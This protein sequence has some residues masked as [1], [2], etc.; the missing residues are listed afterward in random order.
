MSNK[1][2]YLVDYLLATVVNKNHTAQIP[3]FDD[4]SEAEAFCERQCIT[5][6]RIRKRS[7]YK[8]DSDFEIRN[9]DQNELEVSNHEN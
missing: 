2:M 8:P 6:K 4:R 3:V 7:E 9:H 5:K 1:T